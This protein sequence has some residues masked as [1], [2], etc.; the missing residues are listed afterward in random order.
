MNKLTRKEALRC[1][2]SAKA[3]KKAMVDKMKKMLYRRLQITYRR[4][5]CEILCLVVAALG[6]IK[7]GNVIYSLEQR[8]KV[9]NGGGLSVAFTVSSSLYLVES[10][11]WWGS[12][13]EGHQ[14]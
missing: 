13:D 7:L 11:S 9:T 14:T 8:N 4:G 6:F 1:W 3:T 10:K 12:S 5:V 2:K